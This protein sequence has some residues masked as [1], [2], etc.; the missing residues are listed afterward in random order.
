MVGQRKIYVY[1]NLNKKVATK[2]NL[3]FFLKFQSGSF[4]FNWSYLFNDNFLFVVSLW[5]PTSKRIKIN[6]R[7]RKTPPSKPAFSGSTF[8]SRGPNFGGLSVERGRRGKVASG[9]SAVA[10]FQIFYGFQS[11]IETQR[12][13]IVP[14]RNQRRRLCQR[15]SSDTSHGRR[16][17]KAETFSKRRKNIIG[18]QLRENK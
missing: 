16:T 5:S 6:Q 7:G 12:I 15:R 8:E 18:N 1:L 3:I 17:W 4:I 14:R 9:V 13:V 11:S 2:F 10:R